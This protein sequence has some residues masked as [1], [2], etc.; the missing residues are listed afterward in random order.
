MV[1]RTRERF[2]MV[3]RRNSM[4]SSG[5]TTISAWTSKS[6][7]RLRNSARASEKMASYPAA[8]LSDGWCEVDQNSPEATSLR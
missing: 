7:S 1:R 2:L 6:F 8:L 5:E 4:S 3:V